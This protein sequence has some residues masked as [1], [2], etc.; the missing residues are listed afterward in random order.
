MN[1]FVFVTP[2][3]RRCMSKHGSVTNQRL[4]SRRADV[5]PEVL[6]WG[7]WPA[8][9]QPPGST[10]RNTLNSYTYLGPVSLRGTTNGDL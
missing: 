2:V 5:V 4:G 3:I 6:M 9:L 1:W 7:E 10:E 8:P